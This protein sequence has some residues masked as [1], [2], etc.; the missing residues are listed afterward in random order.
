[1]TIKGRDLMNGVPKEI[2][3]TE[4]QIS[5]ALAE[6]VSQIVESVKTAL[7]TRHPNYPPISSIK[8]SF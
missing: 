8:G 3:M 2:T 4:R 5:E 1:M 7:E 6:P